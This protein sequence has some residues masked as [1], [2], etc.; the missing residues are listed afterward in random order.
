MISITPL[1][2]VFIASVGGDDARYRL[3]DLGT[4]GG[5]ESFALGIGGDG[6]VVGASMVD[7]EIHAFCYGAGKMRDLG[8]LTSSHLA[9]SEGSN[10]QPVQVPRQP[11][12]VAGVASIVGLIKSGAGKQILA[13]PLNRAKRDIPGFLGLD[14]SQKGDLS[15]AFAVN[16]AGDAVG[17][18]NLYHPKGKSVHAFLSTLDGLQDLGTLGGSSSAAYGINASQAVVGESQVVGDQYKE[19]FLFEKGKMKSLGTLG[20][21][22][23]VAIA[24]NDGGQIAGS[25]EIKGKKVAHAF[26]YSDGKLKDLGSLGESDSYST[27]ISQDGK[28]AGYSIREGKP[29]AFLFDEGKMV[30]LP[31]LGPFGSQATGVNK[32]GQVVGV[33]EFPNHTIHGFLYEKGKMIDLNDIMGRQNKSMTITWISG[34]ND[35]GQIVGTAQVGG[36][37]HA[38][39]LEPIS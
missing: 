30:G 19:A 39:L 15:K 29:Q 36:R 33:T 13:Q 24:I 20:G 22:Q 34:I 31:E 10:D 1:L 4:L 3:T 16:K 26:L 21:R 17:F 8:V 5:R 23:S 7:N 38:I 27:A 32:G 35:Q 6:Q 37:L 11:N 2:L 12:P 9:E 14:P 18:S 28:V 25:S